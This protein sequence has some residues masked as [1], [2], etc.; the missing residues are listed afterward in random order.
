[1]IDPAIFRAL[2]AQGATPEMLLAVVE[3]DAAVRAERLE[4]KRAGNAERQRRFRERH[5][6]DDDDSNALRR[7]T[8]RDSALHP[9]LE[10]PP[11]TPPP[12]PNPDISPLTPRSGGRS[13][14]KR[15]PDDW[16]LPAA[17]DLPPRAKA[18]A[19][20]WTSESYETHGEA[21]AAY[22]HG[23]GKMMVDWRATWANRVVALHG[24]VMRDQRFGN[25]PK[26]APAPAG[27]PLPD[28]EWNAKCD[29]FAAGCR[30]M[31]REREAAEWEGK[32]RAPRDDRGGRSGRP[33]PIGELIAMHSAA[34]A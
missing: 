3:A 14:K 21:F 33:K 9:S 27:P 5:K 12:N 6:A 24:Q 18:C 31:G 16:A 23:N 25:D 7:V 20:Q 1:M 13:G 19:E 15:L 22:W 10:V 2:V 4:S 8:E 11:Q 28:A 34:V 17:S 29:L 30:S 26:A 32:K